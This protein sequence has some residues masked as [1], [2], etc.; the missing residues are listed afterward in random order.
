MN[1]FDKLYVLVKFGCH[2]SVA[3]RLSP[4]LYRL[5]N[6]ES[7]PKTPFISFY[8]LEIDRERERER[9]REK[10]SER[11]RETNKEIKKNQI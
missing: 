6:A 7:W 2:L 3:Y 10:E 9:E 4:A 5:T 11:K 8:R 1:Y